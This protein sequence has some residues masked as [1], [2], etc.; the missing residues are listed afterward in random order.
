MQAVIGLTIGLAI[1][2]SGAFVPSPMAYFIEYL[3]NNAWLGEIFGYVGYI[4][5]FSSIFEYMSMWVVVFYSTYMAYMSL[6]L[7]KII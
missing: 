4:I 7:A 1:I 5:P 2:M 3:E 6:K